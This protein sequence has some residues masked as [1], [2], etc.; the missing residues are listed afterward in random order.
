[1]SGRALCGRHRKPA[2]SLDPVHQATDTSLMH[3]MQTSRLGE[4][5]TGGAAGA[6]THGGKACGLWRLAKEGKFMSEG[7]R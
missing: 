6:R 2:K 1:M 7:R 3:C 4:G 5:V